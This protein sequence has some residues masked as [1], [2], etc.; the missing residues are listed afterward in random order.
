MPSISGIAAMTGRLGRNFCVHARKRRKIC[1]INDLAPVWS[2]Q[3][4]AEPDL[5]GRR[6]PPY[7]RL[8]AAF[9][10]SREL[11]PTNTSNAPASASHFPA[12]V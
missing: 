8:K 10:T 11:P 4:F 7:F 9:F 1:T 5:D 2:D 12:A 6:S 3:A